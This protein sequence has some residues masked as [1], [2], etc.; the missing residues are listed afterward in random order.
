MS[1]D[2]KPSARLKGEG[3]APLPSRV[4]T[5]LSDALAEPREVEQMRVARTHW[6]H[7][8]LYRKLGTI[9]HHYLRLANVAASLRKF[10][11]ISQREVL[12]DDSKNM[13]LYLAK[14]IYQDHKH[15]FGFLP[16]WALSELGSEV[17]GSQ[18]PSATPI[19]KSPSSGPTDK[20]SKEEEWQVKRIGVEAVVDTAR[21]FFSFGFAI[22]ERRT[23]ELLVT[24]INARESALRARLQKQ[25]EALDCG[26]IN[27]GKCNQCLAVNLYFA[28]EAVKKLTSSQTSALV[29]PKTEEEKPNV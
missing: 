19:H 1:K 13:M 4:I 10:S 25:E 11:E 6:A 29:H 16:S 5:K 18:A 22:S 28:L 21:G 17:H 24:A 26:G 8:D 2:S 14:Q 7:D 27:C 9:A 23:L 3:E 15:T 12:T 20:D